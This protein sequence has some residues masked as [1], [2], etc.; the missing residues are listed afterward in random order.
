MINYLNNQWINGHTDLNVWNMF[1]QKGHRT[2]NLCEGYNYKLGSKKSISKHPNPYLL[3]SIIQ[4]ELH[5]TRDNAYVHVMGKQTKRIMHVTIRKYQD[6]MMANYKKGRIALHV[7][8]QSMGGFHIQKEARTTSDLDPDPF[9]DGVPSTYEHNSEHT[10]DDDADDDTAA[11]DDI[12]IADG[13]DLDDDINVPVNDNLLKPISPTH[14]K[15]LP[16]TKERRKV[17]HKRQRPIPNS[18]NITIG[19]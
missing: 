16:K 14:D 18:R 12:Y 15:S 8:M 9:G 13:L 1:N 3:C 19:H 4:D 5:V 7:Y 11:E 10:I 6:K 2:N 17:K